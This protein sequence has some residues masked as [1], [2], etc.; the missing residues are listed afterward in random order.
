V[1]PLRP[2]HDLLR[3]AHALPDNSRPD[4]GVVERRES[5]IIGLKSFNNWVKSVLI[6]KFA[7]HAFEGAA[8]MLPG[9]RMR[10]RVLDM[11]CGKGGDLQKWQ[12]AHVKEYIGLGSCIM[13]SW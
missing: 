10:G 13:Y 3:C 5:P 11:G 7:K 2:L 8:P 1:L 9:E 12:K 6:A 4:V